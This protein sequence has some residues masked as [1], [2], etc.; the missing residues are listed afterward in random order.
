[1]DVVR[2]NVE[3]I[4]GTIEVQSFAGSGTLFTIKIPL[5]LAIVSALLVEAGG[6]RFALPQ[7]NIQELI[8]VSETSE[9]SIE[10]ISEKPLLRLRDELVP[11]VHLSDLL[12]LENRINIDESDVINSEPIYISIIQASNKRIGIVM[13][14]VTFL[15][16]EISSHIQPFFQDNDGPLN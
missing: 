14:P 5:T 3:K 9:S 7:L 10:F 1:M 6:H 16:D 8:K 4:N 12:H 2:S 13:L 15:K 11:L